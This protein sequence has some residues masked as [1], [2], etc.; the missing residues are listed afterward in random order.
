MNMVRFKTRAM[1][2]SFALA[3]LMFAEISAHAQDPEAQGPPPANVDASPVVAER[4]RDTITLT[5]SIVT[6]RASEVSAE[7]SARV[8]EVLADAGDYVEK[9]QVLARLRAEPVRLQ[10]D[11]ARGQLAIEEAKLAELLNGSRAEDIEIERAQAE[12]ARAALELATLDEDRARE[13][14]ETKVVSDSEY[15][16]ARTSKLGR[17]A[18]WEREQAQYERTKNGPRA[19][20]I[21]SQRG[22]VEAAAAKVAQYADML[23]RHEI[24]APY[25]GV[26]GAKLVEAGQWVTPGTTAF[27][28]AELD[29]LRVEVKVPERHFNDVAPGTPARVMIDAVPGKL[30]D[31][32]ISHRI[33]LANEASRTFPVRVEFPN[34][35]LSVAPGMFARATFEIGPEDEEPSIL[36]PRD[37]IVMSP[38]RSQSVWVVRDGD[39]GPAAFPETVETGRSWKG[40][41]EV[42]SEGLRPG[43]RVI[44]RGNERLFPSQPVNVREGQ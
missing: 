28:I 44:V 23:E 25:N 21:A 2:I 40:S 10:I 20:E 8:A 19:E 18:A 36:V 29:V 43:D 15:D 4:I 30:V 9:G 6:R 12:E 17:K 24:R 33:P 37:A 5:G 34:A 41:I 39:A 31:A 35:D 42:L 13:L 1:R 16:R 22:E 32:T 7:V 38:D 14:F 26:L 3:T 11:E 27:T